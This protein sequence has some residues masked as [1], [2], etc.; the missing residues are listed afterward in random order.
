MLPLR[1]RNLRSVV[2]SIQSISCPSL[3][4]DPRLHGPLTLPPPGI[5]WHVTTLDDLDLSRVY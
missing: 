4:L 1:G 3:L 5:L 2:I